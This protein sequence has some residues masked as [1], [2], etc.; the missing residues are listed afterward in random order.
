[1]EL[2]AEGTA[3]ATKLTAAA[4]AEAT[5]LNAQADAEA[6]E[7]KGLAEARVILEQGKS[8]A[9]AYK[10]QV[11]AMG[12]DVFGQIQVVAKI[13]ESNLKLI[14]DVYVGGGQGGD[15]NPLMS[16]A[17][18][19]YLTGRALLTPQQTPTVHEERLEARV[20]HTTSG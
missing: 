15:Q 11:D 18:L 10:Q 4:S 19:Q 17:L 6:I 13:A 9:E 5:R 14:P 1:M 2:R 3:K 12:N 7:K 16:L 8:N 20:T